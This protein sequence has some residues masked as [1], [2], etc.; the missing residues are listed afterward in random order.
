MEHSTRTT[1]SVVKG[2]T[3]GE[4]AIPEFQRGFVWTQRQVRDLVDS[5]A[6]GFPVGSLLTW[7]SKTA[8]Q[9]GDSNQPQQRSWLIDGQQRTTALCTIFG[10]RPEWWDHLRGDTWTEHLDRFDVRLDISEEELSFVVR[11]ASNKSRYVPVRAILSEQTE[12]YELARELVDA[13]HTYTEQSRE[14]S[15]A[16]RKSGGPQESHIARSQ[17]RR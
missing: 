12:L 2:A 9:R 5:L 10:R 1:E 7:K 15:A 6:C 17:D 11:R 16:I 13:G 14:D 8:I 4:F 3:E